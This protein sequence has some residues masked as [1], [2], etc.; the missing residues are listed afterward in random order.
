MNGAPKDN[1]NTEAPKVPV[2]AS[3]DEDF[4]A[5]DKYRKINESID[6]IEID[7]EE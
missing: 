3:D 2:E 5:G 7:I 4:T 6:E 1:T